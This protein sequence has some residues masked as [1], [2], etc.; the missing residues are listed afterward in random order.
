MRALTLVGF[1]IV[2]LLAIA[3]VAVLVQPADDPGT[4]PATELPHEDEAVAVKRDP[5]AAATERLA[6]RMTPPPRP[7]ER[8]RDPGE[9]PLPGFVPR[10]LTP[11]ATAPIPGGHPPAPVGASGAGLA[12]PKVH[13]LPDGGLEPSASDKIWPSDAAGIQGAIRAQVPEIRDCYE[14]WLRQNPNLAGKITL[15]F[16][17]GM[18]EGGGEHAK[19]TGV[20]VKDSTVN[21]VFMQGCVQSVVSTMRFTKPEGGSLTVS[22][23]MSFSNNAP[24]GPAAPGVAGGAPDAG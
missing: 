16:T 5:S 1:G 2:G 18:G 17:I 19:V 22:Y 10:E 8:P 15:R 6:R 24:D 23:P 21:N 12:P 13:V 14:Q 3:A 7:D 4:Q 20:G 11:V 9:R